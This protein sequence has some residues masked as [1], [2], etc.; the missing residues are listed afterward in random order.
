[1]TEA[2]SFR[3]AIANGRCA[4]YYFLSGGISIKGDGPETWPASRAT[5]NEWMADF[6]AMR[7]DGKIARIERGKDMLGSRETYDVYEVAK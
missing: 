2:T 3:D 7:A 5:A 1:M 4:R 6:L